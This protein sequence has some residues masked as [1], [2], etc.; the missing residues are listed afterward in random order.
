MVQL[1]VSIVFCI[2]IHAFAR[3]QTSTRSDQI[4]ATPLLEEVPL[5][6]DC[7]V[8]GWKIHNAVQ[9]CNISHDGRGNV[10]ALQDGGIWYGA[11]W[12]QHQ[13]YTVSHHTCLI[14]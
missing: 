5:K 11:R 7:T 4:L 10:L 9:L 6:I 2:L 8:A 3:K 13:H 1:L 14:P 12:S